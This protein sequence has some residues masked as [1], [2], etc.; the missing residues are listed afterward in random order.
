M[1]VAFI[2]TVHFEILAQPIRGDLTNLNPNQMRWTILTKQSLK[3]SQKGLIYL[4]LTRP[5]G[6]PPHAPVAQKIADQ[7]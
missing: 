2:L 7:R 4:T 3:N 6:S 1:K 5:I